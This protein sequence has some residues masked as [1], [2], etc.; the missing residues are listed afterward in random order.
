MH[1]SEGV[2]RPEILIGGAVLST[3]L[4]FYAFKT[5]K[6][7]EIPKTAVLSALFFLA[8]FIHIPLGPT[9]VHL[10]LGGIVGALLTGVFAA[11][12]LGGFG[13]VEDIGLQL[14]I[15]FKGVIFTVIYTGIIT[16]V[17]LKALDMV[18]GLRVTEESEQI[19]LDLSEHNERG[20]N[21]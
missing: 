19:G 20:Y 10:V 7:E 3:A 16:Y 9:S 13:T 11:P 17:I 18:M 12:A 15:Q 1:I 14:W 6:N 2:L 21:L 8:S 4:V 5:L